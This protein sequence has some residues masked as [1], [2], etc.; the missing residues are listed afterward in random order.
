MELDA[1][2]AVSVLLVLVAHLGFQ[3]FVPGGLGVTIFFGISGF[4]ITKLILVEYAKYGNVNI[5]LF[6]RRR[7]WKI[8]PP[9]F[10]LIILPSL[11]VWNHY[12]ISFRKFIGLLFFTLNWAQIYSNPGNFFPPSGV[13]WSLAIEEQFYIGIATVIALLQFAISGV[14]VFQKSL[15]LIFGS[16]W[17]LS[18]LSRVLIS[19]QVHLPAAYGDTGNLLR[20]Y[21]GTDTRISSIC[22]G[23][24]IAILVQSKKEKIRELEIKLWLKTCIFIA[25]TALFLISLTV[26]NLEFRNTFRYTLQE[27]SIA[28]LLISGPV[29]DIWPKFIQKIAKLPIVQEVGK[30]SYTIY[31]SH[32]I[33]YLILNALEERFDL[34][35]H[36]A[37]WKIFCGFTAIIVGMISHRLVDLPFENRRQQARR[38]S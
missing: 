16:I 29:L 17:I 5:K 33:I 27:I 9:F 31:L 23:A 30:S 28:L 11:M 36:T 19:N 32:P 22:S 37:V 1:L 14:R 15:T 13:A 20:I 10:F 34:N 21:V 12:E 25:I 4:I 18:T 24:L 7:F 3:H 8:A 35:I 6:Y 2:R 26:R 38:S